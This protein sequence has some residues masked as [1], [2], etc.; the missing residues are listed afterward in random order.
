MLLSNSIYTQETI[1]IFKKI[2]ISSKN[3]VK[4]NNAKFYFIYI[5]TFERYDNKTKIINNYKN[6]V[7]IIRIIKNLNLP[8]IDLHKELLVNYKDPL[9]LYPF[10]NHGHFT[11]LGYDLVSQTIV[12]KIY[13]L[14]N[15]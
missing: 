1:K 3:L 8:I 2:I 4:Q 9:S 12:E 5:P 10:R 6:Y 14:E 15:N 11:E 7:D 13:Q